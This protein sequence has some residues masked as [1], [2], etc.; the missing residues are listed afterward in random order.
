MGI[1]KIVT[2]IVS[3]F[4]SAAAL[5]GGVY[6]KIGPH[7]FKIPQENALDSTGWHW[8]R[9][10][11]GL[12][13]SVS[14]FMF[15][16]T[17]DTML[18]TMENHRTESVRNNS[19]IIGS[20]YLVNRVERERSN[21]LNKLTDLWYAREG[22]ERREVIFDDASGYYFVFEREGYRG[23][24]YVFSKPPE[25]DI[26]SHKEEFY[27]AICSGSSVAEIKHASC[28]VRFFIEPDLQ[29]NFSVPIEYLGKQ[30]RI[31]NYIKES[32]LE[33]LN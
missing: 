9:S 14:S 29:V 25:S 13:E 33:W 2:L 16:F 19:K 30:E 21:D 17:T 23:M 4:F 18:S 11:V 26:P 1:T 3:C 6:Y 24:F 20:V 8:L 28:K 32:L 12:D 15:S 7:E 10:M 27:M 31:K 5:G 22:Y